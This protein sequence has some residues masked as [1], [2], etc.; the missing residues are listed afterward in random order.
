MRF[1]II[2]PVHNGEKYIEDCLNSALSECWDFKDA[3]IIVVENGSTD[4]TGLICDR[5]EKRTQEIKVVH[6]GPIG[7]YMARQRGIRESEGEWIVALDADDRL[8]PGMLRT[9]DEKIKNIEASGKAVDMV[10]FGAADLDD[11]SRRLS[12]PELDENTVYSGEQKD[13]FKKLI[14]S[15][16]SI[17]AMWI[18]CVRKSMAMI[19]KKQEGLNYGEDL[20][21]SAV[22]IDRAEG[23]A[24][25]NKPL[26][27]YRDNASS[28]SA[29]YNKAYMDNQKFVWARIDELVKQW[30]M[31]DY[32][33]IIS[34]RKSLTCAIA[35]SKILYSGNGIRSKK[36]ELKALMEDPF[37]QKYAGLSLPFWAPEEDVFVHMLMIRGD[38][39]DALISNARKAMFKNSVKK[40]IRKKNTK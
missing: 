8:L 15:D 10:L 26:Y 6:E 13:V 11:Q 27:L 32:T 35:V 19:D 37:Y 21:Q 40:L 30:G 3:Q 16:D 9:L 12:E 1:S 31:K 2:V 24:Y 20:Y 34:S 23:I 5:L 25:I 22:Y 36:S 18:K 39:Y 17:N 28:L 14:C 4:K 38:A 29:T 33:D 7:L